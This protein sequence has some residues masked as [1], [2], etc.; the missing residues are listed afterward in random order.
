MKT[1]GEI[2][3]QARL[4]KGLTLKQLAQ[5]TKVRPDY[6]KHIETSNFNQLP[7]ATFVKSFIQTYSQAVGLNPQNVLAV[8]RRDYDQN[9]KG[10]IIP[11]GMAKP[12]AQP[13]KVWNPRTTT[14][15]I[16][17]VLVTLVGGYMLKQLLS[18]NA[19]PQITLAEPEE[20]QTYTTSSIEVLGKTSTDATITI[21]QKPVTL[22]QDGTFQTTLDLAPGDHTVIIT[23]QSRDGKTRTLSRSITV[24][25]P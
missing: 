14:F 19:A 4:K 1:V 10:K 8:F 5:K 16:A 9:T 6:L 3:K 24:T 11:R 21:N 13:S 17:L 7:S 25:T 18:L 22:K 2:L 23:S 20:G 12:L 15:F